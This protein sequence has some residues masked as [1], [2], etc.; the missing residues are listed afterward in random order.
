MNRLILAACVLTASLLA[1]SAHA[2]LDGAYR[3]QYVSSGQK[4]C[5]EKAATDPANAGVDR[6]RLS[7]F[8]LCKMNYIADRVTEAHLSA[9]HKPIQNGGSPQIASVSTSL[10]TLI[11]ASSAYCA[12]R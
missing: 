5:L 3:S 9:D 2:R 7:A 12:A 6:A 4:A 1:T 11:N 10:A 8:C